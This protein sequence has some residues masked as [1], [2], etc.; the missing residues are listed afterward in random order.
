MFSLWRVFGNKLTNIESSDVITIGFDPPLPLVTYAPA[1]RK[2]FMKSGDSL[3]NEVLKKLE[4][5]GADTKEFSIIVKVKYH[6]KLYDALHI[7]I[8]SCE[9]Y[10]LVMV[11]WRGIN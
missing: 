9:Q 10:Y 1:G 6:Q 11:A 8:V 7:I 3:S 5:I 4:E 2:T